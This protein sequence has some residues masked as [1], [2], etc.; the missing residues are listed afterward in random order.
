MAFLNPEGD[1]SEEDLQQLMALGIIPD[2]QSGLQDQLAQA[3]KLRYGSMPGMRGEGGRVQT[4]ANP[5][6]FLVAGVQGYKA[7][8]DITKLR[9]EQQDL[10]KQQAEARKLFFKRLRG[11]GQTPPIASEQ[12]SS[13]PEY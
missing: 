12:Y 3:Q 6:E 2:Q 5:L 13:G 4:A 9:K 7:G 11:P 8:K 1:L 10:L